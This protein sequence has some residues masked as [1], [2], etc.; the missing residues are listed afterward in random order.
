MVGSPKL[1]GPCSMRRIERVGEASLSREAMIQAAV[2][3]V[4]G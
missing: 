2:P 4:G 1:F 3:P